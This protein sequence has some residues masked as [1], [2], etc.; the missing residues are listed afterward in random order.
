VRQQASAAF[1]KKRSKKFLQ[2]GSGR[3]N[4]AE[5]AAAVAQLSQTP[6][7]NKSILVLF[8]KKE[9]LSSFRAPA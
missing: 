3:F 8:F 9:R 6:P 1:L 5:Y 4:S 2:L 7:T